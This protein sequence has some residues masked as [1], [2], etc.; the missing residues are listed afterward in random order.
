VPSIIRLADL[1]PNRRYL[2]SIRGELSQGDNTTNEKTTAAARSP[3]LLAEPVGQV[4][5]TFKT[6]DPD[7]R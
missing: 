1:L 2:V 5:A 6:P 3:L 7:A 4:M